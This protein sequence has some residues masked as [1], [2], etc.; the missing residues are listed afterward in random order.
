[1]NLIGSNYAI[2]SNSENVANVN[3]QKVASFDKIPIVTANM[4][5][6]IIEFPKNK[7][8]KIKRNR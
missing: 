8:I 5:D 2:T 7:E 6:L 1:M 4:G 3:I